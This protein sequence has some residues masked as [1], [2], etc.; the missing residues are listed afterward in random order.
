MPR[1]AGRSPV[2]RPE[3]A[4]RK[5]C[6]ASTSQC[7]RPSSNPL[8]CIRPRSARKRSSNLLSNMPRQLPT[9]SAKRS[10]PALLSRIVKSLRPLEN[11]A[12]CQNAIAGAAAAGNAKKASRARQKNRLRPGALRTVIDLSPRFRSS[13]LFGRVPPASPPGIAAASAKIS[14]RPG[15]RQNPP[16]K[17]L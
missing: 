9:P 7:S 14:P 2:R 8:A 1:L 5:T 17:N 4:A 15:F 3:R 11:V 12:S 10:G 6:P 16:Q 13:A